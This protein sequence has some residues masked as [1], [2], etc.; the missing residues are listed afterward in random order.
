MLFNHEHFKQLN[1]QVEVIDKKTKLQVTARINGLTSEVLTV[2]THNPHGSKEAH[3]P[4]FLKD[5]GNILI[6]SGINSADYQK[7]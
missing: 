3:D 5:L 2:G 7:F 1:H 4:Q 6:K